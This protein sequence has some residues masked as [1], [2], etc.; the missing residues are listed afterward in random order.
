MNKEI[1]RNQ[2]I[3]PKKT[4]KMVPHMKK[5]GKFVFIAHFSTPT[6]KKRERKLNKSFIVTGPL[7]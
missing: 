3:A 4:I 5:L 7:E 1:G 6:K 2:F